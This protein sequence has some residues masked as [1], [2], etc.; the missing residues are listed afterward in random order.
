[1]SRQRLIILTVAALLAISA[2]LLLAGRRNSSPDVHGTALLPSLGTELDTVTSVSV[3]KGSPTPTVT[4]HK[5]GDQWTVVQRADY[6]ADVSKVRKLLLALSDARIREEKTS[7][8]ESYAVIGVEDALK[9]GATGSQVEL[10]AKSGKLDVIVGKPAGQG[11]F[12]RRAAEKTSYA[13][14]P[15]ISFEAE[16]RFWIDTRLL[17]IATDKIQSIEFKP[18][19]GPG[20]TLRRVTEPAPKTAE[21]KTPAP[22]A[23][24]AAPAT[25]PAPATAPTPALP[26]VSKFVL[27]GVPSG[28]QANDANSI[29]P[30]PS[31]FSSLTDED[32]SPVA[33]IDFSKPS[34]LTLTLTDGA[35]ITLTGTAVGDKRWMQI[36]APKDA[37]LTAKANGRAFEIASY[38]YDQLFRPLEQLLV[39]KPAPTPPKSSVG[40]TS[41]PIAKKPPGP[42]KP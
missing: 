32:V 17:D 6:P 34:I 13:A 31:T 3:F 21:A 19:S 23:A 27:D 40:Q 25:P 38:R 8:P 29:A 41:L 30:L 1:M 11:N 28:R 10:L 33:D 9:A 5:Q 16:P 2:A 35:V 42:P 22:A 15:S 7:N 36:A 39:P 26:P 20:Y 18:A 12:V 37:A 4:V 24:G 14:E